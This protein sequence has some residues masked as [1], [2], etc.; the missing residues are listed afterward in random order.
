MRKEIAEAVKL[1]TIDSSTVYGSLNP[2]LAYK[3]RHL[4]NAPASKGKDCLIAYYMGVKLTRSEAILAKCCC[5]SGHYGESRS[6][7]E[8][9]QCPLHDYMPYRPKKRYI[10]PD[11]R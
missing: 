11:R 5:C 7:C 4:E 1:F 9:E 2:I 3:L 6:D 10:R 8:N